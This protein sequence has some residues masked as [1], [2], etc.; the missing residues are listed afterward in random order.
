M[1]ILIADDD[2]ISKTLLHRTLAR[3][4]HEVE[5]FDDGAALWARF[6]EQPSS[7]VVTDWMMPE[8]DGVA[9]CRR[10]RA[11][12]ADEYTHVVLVT[13]L[14]SSEKTVEALSA[15]VDDFLAKP[16]PP[17]LLSRQVAAAARSIL[18]HKEAALRSSLE[19]CEEALGVDHEKL[20][21]TLEELK[22]VFRER[23]A[24][25]RC[26]AFVRRQLAIARRAHG[27]DDPRT[28]RFEAELEE[29]RGLGLVG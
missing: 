18:A 28:R 5:A 12:R 9:L 17:E 3:E 10:I 19:V 21:A 4:G 11:E 13:T 15:G 25:V 2:P 29:L 20:L 8:L 23:R 27:P 1:R 14:S 6:E 26:R 16:V 24:H 7:L 22:G